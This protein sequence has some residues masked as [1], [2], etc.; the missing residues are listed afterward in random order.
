MRLV[1]VMDKIVNMLFGMLKRGV[2]VLES[3]V[4]ITKTTDTIT[5]SIDTITESACY[6][7]NRNR[8][9]NARNPR[10]NQSHP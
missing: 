4:T 3:K 6:T 2:V 7:S 5:E 1:F 8:V 9:P 10:K